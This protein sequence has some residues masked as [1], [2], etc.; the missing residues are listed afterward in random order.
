MCCVWAREDTWKSCAFSREES[1]DR[2]GNLFRRTV[3]NRRETDLIILIT[4]R[5]VES[6][7]ANEISKRIEHPE[8]IR[9]LP[10]A[11][12]ISPQT[13]GGRQ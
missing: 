10:K 6:G 5:L 8:I 7:S 3:K 4:P 1:A 13:R 12:D 11:L 2:R 9:M